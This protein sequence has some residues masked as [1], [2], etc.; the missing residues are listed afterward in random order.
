MASLTSNAI[1]PDQAIRDLLW[2]VNSPSLIN[3][4][5]TACFDAGNLQ[6]PNE[7]VVAQLVSFLNSRATFRVG[8]YFEHLVHFYL[9]Y[10]CGVELLA[11]SLQIQRKTR[12]IGEIDFIFRDSAGLTVHVE[13][14][15][16]FYLHLAD[17]N[18]TG[19]HLVGPNSADTFERKTERLF[20]HQLP[21]SDQQDISVDVCLPFVRGRI[22]YHRKHDP[23]AGLPRLLSETHLCETWIRQSELDVLDEIQNT[24][25][26]AGRFRILPKPFWLSDEVSATG[27]EH[28]M[29]A[30]DMKFDLRAHFRS[31]RRPRLLSVL[32]GDTQQVCETQ[33]IFVVDDSW[34][35]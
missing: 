5:T 2:V 30:S 6:C 32:D 21:L 10:I 1:D 11:R 19:S 27:S 25:S 33:R 24:L 9:Q 15:V 20:T 35:N 29:T 7:D 17:D 23:D 4:A 34:P 18:H 14:A 16:K 12:T 3:S 8:H 22:F 28:L 31:D 26:S 13:T